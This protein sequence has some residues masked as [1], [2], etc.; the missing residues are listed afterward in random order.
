VGDDIE[1]L[2]KEP[3]P[4]EL[5]EHRRARP[6]ERPAPV[7]IQPEPQPAPRKLEVETSASPLIE[8]VGGGLE[9]KIVID[10]DIL[11]ESREQY[12]RLAATLHQ[13]QIARGIKVVMVTS[14]LPS[15][16]K[17]LTVTN[18]ALTFSESYERN[19]LLIDSDLRRPALHTVFSIK[20][21]GGLFHTLS[22]DAPKRVTVRQVSKRLSV[23]PA[24]SPTNDPMAG[25]TSDRLR[26]L[27]EEARDAFDWV[28]IDTP[29]LALL[30][31][32]HL[33]TDVV[34]AALLVVKAGATPYELVKR[35]ADAIGGDR[36]LGVVLN[37]AMPV[38][39]EYGYHYA[40]YGAK[41]V[42]RPSS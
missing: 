8:Q 16:G 25:L 3:F 36:L 37:G 22:A 6:V 4:I 11:P 39:G 10:R 20:S 30:P 26:L 19:V 5:N 13:A 24:G 38:L 15:E 40:Y 27:V 17:T 42:P 18:L 35:A 29:P 14:A 33:L 2:A 23:L 41:D 28:L 12:R 34:D 9:E 7:S 1:E 21:E 31:D 32:A